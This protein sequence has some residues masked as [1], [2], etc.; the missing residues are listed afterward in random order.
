M[1]QSKKLV[2][3][4]HKFKQF[5]RE[6]DGLVSRYY[7]RPE[8]KRCMLKEERGAFADISLNVTNQF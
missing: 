3:Q 8:S 5:E 6:Q 2:W 7:S 1:K 4:E